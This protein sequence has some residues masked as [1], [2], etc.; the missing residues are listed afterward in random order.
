MLREDIE[1]FQLVFLRALAA[2]GEDKARVALK[3]GCNL[4]FYFS[5]LRYSE[6]IDFDVASLAKETLRNRVQRLLEAPSVTAPLRQRRLEIIDTSTPKQTATTQR[7]KIGLRLENG[8]V[9]RTKL[10]FSRRGT[11]AGAEF[12]A[13]SDDVRLRHGMTTV[14]STH[15]GTRAAIV[16]KIQ[17]LADRKL[18]QPR[19]A[20]DLDLLFARHDSHVVLAACER[21]LLAPAIENALGIGFDDYASKVLAYL[22]PAQRDHHASREAWNAMQAGVVARLEAL[23]T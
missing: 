3:G 6:D 16:Q 13:V 19:D 2:R 1:Y 23:A 22:E 12:A 17:A 4:R 9:A 14:L 21:T 18:P 8:S 10:E 20:F 7:W 15:Y 5:S 11:I